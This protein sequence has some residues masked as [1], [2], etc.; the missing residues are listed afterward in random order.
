MAFKGDERLC[1]FPTRVKGMED[2]IKPVGD[3]R[4]TIDSV[5]CRYSLQVQA[6]Y[7][8]TQLQ[9]KDYF[10]RLRFPI[11]CDYSTASHCLEC[12]SISGKLVEQAWSSVERWLVKAKSDINRFDSFGMKIPINDSTSLTW[13]SNGWMHHKLKQT[14]KE[15]V[16]E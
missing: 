12:N 16:K 6:L 9:S 5:Y 10:K 3:N 8:I 11:I 4:Y 13:Y 2:F 1:I 15:A 14:E 7:L